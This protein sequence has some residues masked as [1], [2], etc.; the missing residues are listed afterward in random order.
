MEKEGYMYN[1]KVYGVIET[2]EVESN[3]GEVISKT[4]H[5]SRFANRNNDEYVKLYLDNPVSAS[6]TTIPL[7]P[8]LHY[9]LCNMSYAKEGNEELG[10]QIIHMDK[11]QLELIKKRSGLS[12][13][14]V[15]KQIKNLVD[16]DILLQIEKGCYQ[17]N[18]KVFS[19][20]SWVQTGS[21]RLSFE[22][23]KKNKRLN[24]LRLAHPDEHSDLKY[25]G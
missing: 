2:I 12:S 7:S 1:K 22:D 17:V 14:A 19:R 11:T 9:I 15:H 5:S 6:G 16:A 4:R 25:T 3:S 23:N 20:G 8:V 21:S 24:S 13:S 10:G 18:P